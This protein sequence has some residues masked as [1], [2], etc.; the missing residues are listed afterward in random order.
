MTGF[1]SS[2][3]FPNN[4]REPIIIVILFLFSENKLSLTV[5]Q[6]SS[7]D[8]LNLTYFFNFLPPALND[9]KEIKIQLNESKN[10]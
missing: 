9:L 4:A 3:Q 1:F 2:T 6:I 5:E 8:L 7:K 10:V